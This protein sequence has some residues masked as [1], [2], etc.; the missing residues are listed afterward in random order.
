M[1]DKVTRVHQGAPKEHTRRSVLQDYVLEW[2]WYRP[3]GQNAILAD[4]W[5]WGEL[6]YAPVYRPSTNKDGFGLLG[7]S[8][9]RWV[10]MF[11][12]SRAA[13]IVRLDADDAELTRRFDDRGDD[14][15]TDHGDLWSIAGNYR[16]AQEYSP[17]ARLEIDTTHVDESPID[18]DKIWYKALENEELAR[19]ICEITPQ[20]IGNLRPDVLL[21]GDERNVT[22]AHGHETILPFMPVDSSSGIYLLES[23]PDD[24]WRR[25]GIV[26]GNDMDG[27]LRVLWE[28]L[29]R[30]RPVALGRNAEKALKTAE[31][32]EAE[33]DVVSHPAFTRRFKHADKTKYGQDIADAASRK[34]IYA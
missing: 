18:L 12:A 30:P 21:V 26:N 24:L 32:N 33:Y 7:V 10:E 5:H 23:L 4:R 2:E 27:H 14:H 28:A 29:G 6:T 25:V 9:W 16:A 8:G 22:K 34:G 3:G 11:L 19:Q 20:Y 15:V 17:A 31:F 1:G 13:L